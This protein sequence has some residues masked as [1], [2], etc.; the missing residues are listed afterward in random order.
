MS[1]GCCTPA[2]TSFRCPY[3]WRFCGGLR[4]CTRTLSVLRAARLFL[5]ALRG[6][7]AQDGAGRLWTQPQLFF[8]LQPRLAARLVKLLQRRPRLA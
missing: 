6:R 1:C 2:R 5:Q 3:C 4:G 8:L 7:R